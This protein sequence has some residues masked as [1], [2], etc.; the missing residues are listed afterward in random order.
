MQNKSVSRFFLE[1]NSL[2]LL[3]IKKNWSNEL[4]TLLICSCQ[5]NF[6]SRV[7]PRYFVASTLSIFITSVCRAEQI[8]GTGLFFIWKSMK[9]VLSLFIVSLLHVH[10]EYNFSNA[11]LAFHFNSSKSGLQTDKE[12]SSANNLIPFSPTALYISLIYKKKNN[13]PNTDPCET[14]HGT[15]LS[16]YLMPFTTV[17]WRRFDKYDLKKSFAWPLI[18]YYSSLL[19]RISWFTVSKALVRSINILKTYFRSSNERLI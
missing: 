15:H 17:Y 19:R 7:T 4:Q 9:W 2:I 1:T 16:L 11:I 6:S 8:R 13:G 14:P 12:V 3:N 5:V 18:P 10:R